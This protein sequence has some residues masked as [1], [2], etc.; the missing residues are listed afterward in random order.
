[1]KIRKNKLKLLPHRNILLSYLLRLC[2]WYVLYAHNSAEPSQHSGSLQIPRM[3]IN[4]LHKQG[5]AACA[6]YAP[7]LLILL[8]YRQGH[9]LC[10]W[11]SLAP[12]SFAV[13]KALNGFHTKDGGRDLALSLLLSFRLS[14]SLV[15][16]PKRM[17]EVLET[18]HVLR[19][20]KRATLPL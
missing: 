3:R 6:H 17:L 1:M 8:M 10:V 20:L 16:E 18:L 2:L 15:W 13:G 19:S 5:H 14:L 11:C 7:A 9:A 4:E 12:S